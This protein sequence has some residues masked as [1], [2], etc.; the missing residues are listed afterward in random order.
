[1][2]GWIRL[3][4]LTLVTVALAAFPFQTR[5]LQAQEASAR[6]RILVPRVPPAA[7]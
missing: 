1:M 5:T 7:S 2:N 3:G 6:F 4:L